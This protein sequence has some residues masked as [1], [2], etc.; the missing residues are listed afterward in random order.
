MRLIGTLEDENLVKKFSLFLHQKGIVHQIEREINQDWGNV[1]YGLP[2][3]HIWI[4]EEENALLAAQWLRGFKENPQDPFFE[5]NKSTLPSPQQQGASPS[6]TDAPSEPVLTHWDQQ[7]MGPLTRA[8]LLSCC[9]L[10]LFSLTWTTPQHTPARYAQLTFF[11]SPIERALL[12]DYP[13]FYE[14]ISRFI[15]TY[16]YEGLENPEDLPEGGKYLIQKIERTRF[17]PGF[18]PLLLKD[19]FEGLRQNFKS[20]PT[21][22]K[23]RQGEV[24]RLFTPCLLHGDIFH[25]F[26]NM[27]WLIVLG[28]QLEQRLRFFRYAL[29]ILIVGIISNTAQYMMSGP[30]FIGF[31][32]VLCGMLAFIWVRQRNTPWEG[33]QVDRLTMLFILIFVLGMAGLQLLSFL[34]EKNFNFAFAPNIAN[35]AHIVGGITGLIL[36]KL[37]FFS[38]RH[39]L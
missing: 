20:Y 1:S 28:K 6:T 36:G 5:I 39:S 34:V 10:F 22:E 27:I 25:L 30:N 13:T 26:F 38:W 29:F 11:T 12:Y 16:G 19:G 4:E 21:F 33:Y 37:N 8:L 2:F 18:Y 9:L 3:F 14:L 31:S 35:T 15:T 24:W 17:W 23:I 7:P 32:G